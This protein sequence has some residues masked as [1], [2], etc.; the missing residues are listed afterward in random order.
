MINRTCLAR[1]AACAH[2][3]DD[4]VRGHRERRP[5]P[6]ARVTAATEKPSYDGHPT[7]VV[8]LGAVDTTELAELL[9]ASWR[10][11]APKRLVAE[12]DAEA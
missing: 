1:R 8:R 7:V 2:L 12:V 11:R 10:L 4:G 6:R 5:S 3:A 9:D